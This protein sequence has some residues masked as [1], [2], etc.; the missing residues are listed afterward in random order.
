MADLSPSRNEMQ[1][2]ELK[3]GKRCDRNNAGH[4]SLRPPNDLCAHQLFL[5][6]IEAA[7]LPRL[8]SILVVWVM[9]MRVD[10][11]PNRIV[12]CW[13]VVESMAVSPSTH[14]RPSSG[15]HKL[16]RD[17]DRREEMKEQK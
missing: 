16:D 13:L 3:R 15:L 2:E 14:Y 12:G 1:K 6:L 7:L 8:V 9:G 4:A 5:T 11:V 17:L 10:A